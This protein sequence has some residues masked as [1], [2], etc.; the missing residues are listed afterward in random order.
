MRNVMMWTAFWAMVANMGHAVEPKTRLSQNDADRES[1]GL[2]G[3]FGGTGDGRLADLKSESPNLKT[4]TIHHSA[5]TNDGFKHIAKLVELRSLTIGLHPNFVPH[6]SL[7]DAA[8]RHLVGLKNLESLSIS[9]QKVTDKGIVHLKQLP[10][11][12]RLNL[13]VGYEDEIQ[14]RRPWQM[15]GL[16]SQPRPTLSGQAL[17][18]IGELKQLEELTLAD[19]SFTGD[20]LRHLRGLAKLRSLNLAFTDVGNDDLKHLS[21]LENLKSLDLR[22]TRATPRCG[23]HFTKQKDLQVKGLAKSQLVVRTED[24]LVHWLYPP[25]HIDPGVSR[26]ST[27]VHTNLSN[28]EMTPLARDEQTQFDVGDAL[29]RV[30]STTRRVQKVRHDDK[31]LYMLITTTIEIRAPFG[32]PGPRA[33]SASAEIHAYRLSDARATKVWKLSSTQPKEA[34][35]DFVNSVVKSFGL[36]N[37][38]VS[39]QGKLFLAEDVSE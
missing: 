22:G 35:Q 31:Y 11:L 16:D 32:R 25:R 39:C 14:V 30:R 38:G 19:Y 17:A 34:V 23:A 27:I 28:G 1:F 21:D 24:Y 2:T 33:Q 26:S 5:I 7:G 9:A 4:L 15:V 6:A 8:L 3:R 36:I 37:G 10:K 13:N 18:H 29:G 20:D 12:R